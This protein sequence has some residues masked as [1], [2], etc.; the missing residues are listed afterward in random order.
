MSIQLGTLVLRDGMVWENEFLYTGLVQEMKQT[1][2][3]NPVI[4]TATV[5]GPIEISL[6]SM[7]DQGWQTYEQVKKLQE[8]ARTIGGVYT[9]SIGS[10][11]FTVQFAHY[12][13]PVLTVTPLIARTS[14]EDTDY[15]LV[16]LK[17]ISI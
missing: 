11:V 8:M 1:L 12:M 5:S 2:G 6:T 17:L 13:P 3:G 14:Y 9:L 15:F 10:R 16:S 7:D 4:Y